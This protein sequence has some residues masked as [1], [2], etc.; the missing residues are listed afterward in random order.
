MIKLHV[1]DTVVSLSDS[2]WEILA[3]KTQGFSG[4]DIASCVSDAMFEPLRE[5]RDT[6]FWEITTG[7]LVGE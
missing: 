6:H 2:D 3:T 5:L 4:S 7:K 1:K